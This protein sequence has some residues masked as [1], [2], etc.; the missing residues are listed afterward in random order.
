MITIIYEPDSNN[1]PPLQRQL[2]SH[3]FQVLTAT[4]NLERVRDLAGE[5]AAPLGILGAET[6][7]FLRTEEDIRAAFPLPLPP[8]FPSSL[9]LMQSLGQPPRITA[10]LWRAAA[11]LASDRYEAGMACVQLE[12]YQ[13]STSS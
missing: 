13:P 4:D 10:A 2:T 6:L 12:A 5:F 1:L 9:D 3:G 7:E 11:T 8:A